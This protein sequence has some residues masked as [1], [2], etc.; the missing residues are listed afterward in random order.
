MKRKTFT[1]AADAQMHKA[2]TSVL[3]R[4]SGDGF[5][6]FM[7]QRGAGADF[8][9]LYV[10]PG[11]KVDED[12]HH[13][14]LV[15]L[16]ADFDESAANHRL[17][18]DHGALE[19]FT[20]AIRE[21]FEESGV[22]L[23]YDDRGMVDHEHALALAKYREPLQNGELSFI[24]FLREHGLRP[25]VDR[26][27]YLSHWITPEGPPRR[28]DTRFFVAEVPAGQVGQHDDIE[29]VNSAWVRPQ[30]ALAQHESGEFKM[31]FPTVTTLQEIGA[32]TSANGLLEAARANKDI[33][34]RIPGMPPAKKA[35]DDTKPPPA[36]KT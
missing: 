5:E 30:D 10:F 34:T 32:A 27:V 36:H 16:C 31:I 14:D 2:A 20:A 35:A 9:G 7:M 33:P 23:A 29:L 21:C 28:Y 24:D 1:P 13:D 3:V 15:A 22:L 12:D 8:G 17:G 26:P 11:G 18:V 19:Y 4:D 25:A 6:V